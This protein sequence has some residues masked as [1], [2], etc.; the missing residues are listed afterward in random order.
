MCIKRALPDKGAQEG[1][2]AEETEFKDG[3]KKVEIMFRVYLCV[4]WGEGR[5][6]KGSFFL[7]CFFG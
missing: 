6:G 4:L 1:R 2:Q 7:F 5:E 3:S